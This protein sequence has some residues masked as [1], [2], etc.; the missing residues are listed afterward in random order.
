MNWWMLFLGLV[1]IVVSAF[2]GFMAG[3][4]LITKTMVVPSTIMLQ[5][6]IPPKKADEI[7][8][9]LLNAD[10]DHSTEG[11]KLATLFYTLYR[12]GT[13]FDKSDLTKNCFLDALTHNSIVQIAYLKYMEKQTG[14]SFDKEETK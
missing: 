9:L 4:S 8:Y 2:L 11:K 6:V 3:G 1:L 12:L 14:I 7:M 10:D 5:T 13:V